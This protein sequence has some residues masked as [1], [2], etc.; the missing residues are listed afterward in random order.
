MAADDGD[1]RQEQGGG[2][3][4]TPPAGKGVHHHGH[5]QGAQ[6]RGDGYRVQSEH[7]EFQVQSDRHRRAQRGAGRYAHD[8]GVGHGILEETLHHSAGTGQRGSD[9]HGQEGPR[10]TDLPDDRV[11]RRIRSLERAARPKVVRQDLQYAA[12]GDVY[13]ADSHGDYAGDKEERGRRCQYDRS[14]H[15]LS[16]PFDRPSVARSVSRPASG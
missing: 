1:A 6:E 5:G 10:Q 11:R 3:H 16:R 4:A 12:G 13:R 9:E 15:V 14:L 8:I 2:R 7:P